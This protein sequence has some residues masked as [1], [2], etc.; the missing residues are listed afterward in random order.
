M[1]SNKDYQLA[2]SLTLNMRIFVET[3]RLVSMK[4]NWHYSNQLASEVQLYKPLQTSQS[5]KKHLVPWTGSDDS[6]ASCEIQK[7]GDQMGK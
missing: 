2:Y 3:G 1:K 4:L 6:T 7:G 5:S